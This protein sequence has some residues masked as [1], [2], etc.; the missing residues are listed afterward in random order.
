MKRADL[1]ER[2]K[3]AEAAA[4]HARDAA[5][6]PDARFLFGLV[7]RLTPPIQRA[8]EHPAAAIRALGVQ[9]YLYRIADTLE[10]CRSG[11]ANGL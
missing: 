10:R 5:R 11:A 3:A 8:N 6:D 4:I 7:A 2:I 1:P 9:R